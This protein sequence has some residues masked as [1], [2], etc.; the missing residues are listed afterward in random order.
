MM[1]LR[2]K[3]WVK[4]ETKVKIKGE[5]LAAAAFPEFDSPRALVL[6]IGR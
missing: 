6:F 2:K 5:F 3:Y 1:R 4:T